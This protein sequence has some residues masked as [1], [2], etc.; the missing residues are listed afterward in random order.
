MKIVVLIITHLLVAF[1]GFLYGDFGR[2]ESNHRLY[3]TIDRIHSECQSQIAGCVNYANML[4]AELERRQPKQET[5]IE[6]V[7]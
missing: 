4:E 3:S 2:A 7:E 5:H 6:C 1:G